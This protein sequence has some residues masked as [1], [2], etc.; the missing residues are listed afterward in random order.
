MIGSDKAMHEYYSMRAPVYDRVYR[1]P[2]RQKDIRY[3]EAAVP[4]LL[5]GTEVIEIACGT[6]YWTQFIAPAVEAMTATDLS[7]ET[8]ALARSRPNVGAV[9]FRIENA[10][11]LSKELGMFKAAF[12]GLWISHVARENLA[13][14]LKGLH[15]H[16]R[17]GSRVIFLDN[18]KRQC[19]Q[20]PITETD[21]LGNTYQTRTLDDGS[22]H[23]I[24]KNF[25]SAREL[26]TAIHGR[27]KNP[28]FEELEHFW[29][30]M[31]DTA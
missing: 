1:L 21:A 18:S 25:P 3:L 7:A 5:K 28:H 20:V 16:L 17:D 29:L 27:G 8:L 24:L 26:E 15:G 11:A 4:A 10:F 19:L 31:Y 2:E 14:F 9:D 22:Q 6:G 30:F 13:D 23:R 12:A